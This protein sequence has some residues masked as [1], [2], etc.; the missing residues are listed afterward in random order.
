MPF[1]SIN[2][3]VHRYIDEGLRSSPALVFANALGTD[4]RIWDDVA[5]RVL[6]HFRVMRY[7]KRGHGLSEAS[8]PPYSVSDLADDV[9]ALLDELKIERAVMCGISVGGVIAQAVALI[10]PQRV[11]GLVLCDTG[12]RIGSA[13]AWQ[14]RIDM[15]TTE[16]VESVEKM[17]MERWFSAGYREKKPADVRGY[18]AMLCQTSRDGYIG[19]C[20]ALR[21]ADFRGLDGKIKCPTLVLCGAED[22]AT[23]PDLGRELAGSISGARFALIENAAHL[24]CIE[25]PEAMVKQM[26]EF[27]REVKLV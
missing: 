8:L 20:A 14:Q 9:V 11:R 15:I 3:T 26:L 10:Y 18:A 1:I 25:Q 4:L 19:T 21:D 24:P 13:E 5:T 12:A 2:Q 16:G 6:P 7:D 22:I 23:P 27:S 17:T